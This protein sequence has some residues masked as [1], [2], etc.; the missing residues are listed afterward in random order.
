MTASLA[1]ILTMPAASMPQHSAARRTKAPPVPPLENG[2]RLDQKTFHERYEAMPEHVKAELI[3][4]I[5]F[6]ASPLKLPHGRQDSHVI[7]WLATYEDETPGTE[8]LVNSTTIL[9]DEN[10]PQPDAA[11]RIL[12]GGTSREGT[13]KYLYG[14]PELA[15][16][17]AESTES[18]ALHLKKDEY[19]KS[20]IAEYLVVAVRSQKVLW[21]VLHRGKYRELKPDADGILRSRVF[22]GLWLDPQAMLAG[23][24]KRLL[25]VLRE[26]LTSREHAAFVKSLE[27]QVK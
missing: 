9:S 20:K 23:D 22:P 5:V 10:E 2:D 24:R 15:C 6:M 11:L 19:E 3:G 1:E 4:G 27:E 8:V 12:R 16:E 25:A 18:L 17:T 21:F 13:D 26:G 7:H 14:P